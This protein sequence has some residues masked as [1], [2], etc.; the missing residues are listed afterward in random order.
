MVTPSQFMQDCERFEAGPLINFAA[1]ASSVASPWLNKEMAGVLGSPLMKLGESDTVR[2]GLATSPTEAVFLSTSARF[3]SAHMLML[4]AE[5]ARYVASAQALS[6]SPTPGPFA[7]TSDFELKQGIADLLLDAVVMLERAAQNKLN[8]L[9]AYGVHRMSTDRTFE[10]FKAT[11]QSTYGRYSGLTHTD[12]APFG[13]VTM[14]R[15]AIELRVRRAFGAFVYVHLHRDEYKPLNLSELFKAIFEFQ[16]SIHANVDLHDVY[17]VYRWSNPY[18]HAGRRD[19][20]WVAGY[21]LQFL[22]PLFSGSES[23]RSRRG[24]SMHGGLEMPQAAWHS[25]RRRLERNT[26]RN[27]W[28]VNPMNPT[29][30]ECVLY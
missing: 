18:L 20:T 22:R 15:T 5:L 8:I 19:Y 21:A 10:V 1:W 17:R 23:M 4:D 28:V 12:R 24:W 11:E 7:V 27:G 29:D 16:S 30:A 26:R 6:S 13:P 3:Y 14:L 2:A 25:V 9:G